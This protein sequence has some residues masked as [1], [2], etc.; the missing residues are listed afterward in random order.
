MPEVKTTCTARYFQPPEQSLKGEVRD[1]TFFSPVL[2]T[3]MNIFISIGNNSGEKHTNLR[4]KFEDLLASMESKDEKIFYLEKRVTELS[5]CTA[6]WEQL[7]SLKQL[8]G[9]LST[10]RMSHS[11]SITFTLLLNSP[12][13][14]Y[15][16]SEIRSL[17]EG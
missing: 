8:E 3:E 14:I 9:A 15:A 12:L 6:S 1:R 13:V 4:D 2:P 11:F 5:K 10:Q 16:A 7:S 17:A